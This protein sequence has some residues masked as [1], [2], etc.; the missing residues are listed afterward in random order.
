[1]SAQQSSPSE[2]TQIAPQQ[3]G[4]QLKHPEDKPI[5]DESLSEY[6]KMLKF[7]DKYLKKANETCKK[8]IEA[9][10]GGENKP[11]RF[12][13]SESHVC[14]EGVEDTGI[15]IV[16][17]MKDNE[18]LNKAKSDFSTSA[19]KLGAQ[20]VSTDDKDVVHFDLDNVRVNLG[21]SVSKGP[22]VG[23]H[24]KA[25]F[26][27]TTRRD[28]EG[29]LHKDQIEKVSVDLHDSM[30]E[31]MKNK[32]V[33]E[34]DRSAMRLARAWRRTAL[35]PWGDWFSPVDSMLVM[36]NVLNRERGRGGA[37]MPMMG[38]VLRQFFNQLS[39]I[40]SMSLTFPDMSLYDWETVPDW[41]QQEKPLLLDPVNPWRNTFS[42]IERNMLEKIQQQAQQ[43]LKI[44][45]N[46]S[47]KL[48][49][50]FNVPPEAV[51]RGA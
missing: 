23:E 18:S 47:S 41:I 40:E 4:I 50:L 7:D 43:A 3:T 9:L 48:K 30:T 36:Q 33:D 38:N 12:S 35:A 14:Q 20:H 44:M 5:S 28:K 15:D 17:F 6:G 8:V 34:F 45:E 49:E 2:Q 10:K 21:F 42:G 27:Q 22:T 37:Q 26:Q 19:N 13:V 32:Q 11:Q 24:R 51:T 39:N 16:A 46:Q 1:M 31:F 29:R 25:V